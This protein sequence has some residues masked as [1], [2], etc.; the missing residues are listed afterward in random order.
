MNQW[1]WLLI[2]HNGHYKMNGHFSEYRIE[3]PSLMK[4][5]SPTYRKSTVLQTLRF[6]RHDSCWE[7]QLGSFHIWDILTHSEVISSRWLYALNRIGA[8]S[9]WLNQYCTFSIGLIEK[10]D[11]SKVVPRFWTFSGTKNWSFGNNL[12]SGS[13]TI[14]HLR[15]SGKERTNFSTIFKI[16]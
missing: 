11:H 4:I 1:I 15:I 12:C 9:N 2:A 3:W 14:L 8:S 5:N 13:K 16:D 10:F 6:Y 7:L